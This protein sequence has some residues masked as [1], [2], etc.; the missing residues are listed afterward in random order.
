MHIEGQTF[1]SGLGVHAA[2]TVVYDLAGQ[3]TRFQS[4]IGVDDEA[5]FN[6][7]G[8]VAFYVLADG[9]E[10]YNSGQ[11]TYAMGP[12]PIDIDVSGRNQLKLIVTDGGDNKD[13]DHADWADARLT[14]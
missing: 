8:S 11:M 1:S 4:E 14:Q 10:L 6:L 2:S 9:E 5:C 13:C 12:M 3:Y 7:Q